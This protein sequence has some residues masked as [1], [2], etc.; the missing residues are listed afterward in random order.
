[1]NSDNSSSDS[2]DLDQLNKSDQQKT[3]ISA[4]GEKNITER[5]K[6]VVAGEE[7]VLSREKSASVREDVAYSR[8]ET[9]DLRE[10]A[11]QIREKEIL[12]RECAVASREESAPELKILKVELDDQIHKL[13]QANEH[14]AIASTH[15]RELA[16]E[17]QKAKVKMAHLAF[18]DILTDLPNRLQLN[19]R[20]TREIASAMRHKTKFA[21]LFIDLDRFKNI[22]DSLGHTIGDQLLQLVAQRLSTAI[23]STDTLSRQGG[24]EFMILLTGIDEEHA[25]AHQAEKIHKILTLPY[26]IEE[27]DLHIGASIGISMCPDDGENAEMIIKH[28]DAAMYFAKQSGRNKYQFFRQEMNDRVVE[29]QSLET[30]LHSALENQEFELYYQAQIELQ[31][32]SLVGAEALI[33]WHH[34]DK[35]LLL[36][37]FFMPTAEECGAILPIG[38]WVLREACRQAQFWLDAGLEFQIIAVNISTLE[39]ER[40]DFLE[41]VRSVLHDTRLA[42]YHL[43]LEVT[44]TVLMKN[45]EATMVK[46]QALRATGVRISIDDFGTGYSSLSYLKQFP[47]D[48]LKIDQSFVRDIRR[49]DNDDILV[50]TI[51]GIGKNFKYHI[52]AEGIETPEQLTFLRDHQ[53]TGGQGY[54]LNSP[55]QAEE[56]TNY[57]E[58]VHS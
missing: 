21:L 38:R 33:R 39:F 15:S 11:A 47:I 9:A 1:M 30:N 48:T 58:T 22:N 41:H 49:N 5:E 57:L 3:A 34:P 26:T 12:L 10:D 53:C 43:E 55:M 13:Q 25:V 44:E 37:G 32:G 56:F 42:P 36:P 40:D 50:D 19:K 46:L 7:A 8:E 35:G 54:Y 16:E 28:A 29:Q 4:S 51:I 27:H 2:N 18:H 17:I 6:S 24:D 20:L 14:L 31:T 45:V 23:R 52:I